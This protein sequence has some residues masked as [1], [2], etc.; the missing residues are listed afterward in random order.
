MSYL[1]SSNDLVSEALRDALETTEGTFASS[2]ADKVDSLVD[3]AERRHIDSLSADNT[4][5]SDTGGVFAG[6]G[7]RDSINENL[8]WVETGQQVNELHSLLNDTN[9]HLLFTVVSSA[10]GH[11]HVG[12]TL[13]DWALNFLEA[14]LLVAAL[15]VRNVDLLANGLNL[16]VRSETDI[17]AL[18]S[19]VRPFSEKFWL[20]SEFWLVVMITSLRSG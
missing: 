7:V 13:N 5:G 11:H 1:G 10:G 15:C 16:Q 19:I 9:C 3:S 6:T 4:T 20:E 18:N 2:L 14:T 12:E 17:V 8:D